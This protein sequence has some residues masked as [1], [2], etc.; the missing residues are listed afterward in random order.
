MNDSV[1]RYKDFKI[2]SLIIGR[3]GSFLKDKNIL[4]ILGSPLLQWTASAAIK[5]S[6]ISRYYISS[7]CEK[8]LNAG[9]LAGYKKIRR[10]SVLASGN[11]QSC[12]AVLHDLQEIEL[13][14]AV[15]IVVVQHAN[16]ATIKTEMIDDCIKILIDKGPEKCSA[17]IPSHECSEYHPLRAQK[18]EKDGISV[19]Y[20]KNTNPISAN[21]QDLP[22]AIFFD[23]SFWAVWSSSIKNMH[24]NPLNHP[25]PCMGQKIVPYITE[26]CFD[27]H[28]L[29]DIQKTKEWIINNHIKKPEFIFHDN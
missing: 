23:H 6:L 22:K 5:S 20:V 16:V 12:D 24:C 26:G 1:L 2:V 4:K 27:I 11:A 19:P 15:D 7:D 21:R 14:G 29:E 3:G 13:E 10:P 17:V 25:W 28:N 18:I 8:I 9:Q